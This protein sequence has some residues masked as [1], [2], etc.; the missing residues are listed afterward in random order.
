VVGGVKQGG[1][2]ASYVCLNDGTVI[3]AIAGPLNPAE[4][5]RELR[6]AVD[7]RKLAAAQAGGD[8]IK[9]RE[10]VRKGHTER[11]ARESGVRP[12]AHALPDIADSAPPVPAPTDLRARNGRRL[13]AQG[14]VHAILA[15]APVP[16]LSQ[17]YPIV[18]E[19]I[20]GEKVSALPVET[21]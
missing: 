12:A 1:N 13:G 15:T 19:T 11:L 5:L 7:M 18:F 21:K 6:W 4:Y 10:A 2:V 20:L 17:L 3:H 9:Y 16:R 14:Q 8:A